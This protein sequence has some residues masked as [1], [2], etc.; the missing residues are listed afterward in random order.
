MTLWGIIL[1]LVNPASPAFSCHVIS[2]DIGCCMYGINGTLR[3]I[4]N[5]Q[6]Q[7]WMWICCICLIDLCWSEFNVDNVHKRKPQNWKIKN[8]FRFIELYSSHEGNSVY[9][10]QFTQSTTLPI[11]E[12]PD[13]VL[14]VST[15]FICNKSA[16]NLE[17]T[18]I[19]ALLFHYLMLFSPCIAT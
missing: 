14:M 19:T 3:L 2:L 12:H 5:T 15:W 10:S 1:L 8:R 4:G 13:G 9:I 16:F 18:V 7:R 6:M 17:K 11:P